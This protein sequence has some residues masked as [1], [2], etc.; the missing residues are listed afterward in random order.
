MDWP[1]LGI[2][3][4]LSHFDLL[5]YGHGDH[6]CFDPKTKQKSLV[7]DRNI[8][9]VCPSVVFWGHFS[10]RHP[11]IYPFTTRFTLLGSLSFALLWV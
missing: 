2:D 5:S 1:L 9:S 6:S 7:H 10:L 8:F 3:L 4:Q 11:L